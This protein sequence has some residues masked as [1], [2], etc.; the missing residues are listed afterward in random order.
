MTARRIGTPHRPSA[1]LCRRI[2]RH[3]RAFLAYD[4]LVPLGDPVDPR[5]SS[6]KLDAL[7]RWQDQ[8]Y[9][10]RLELLGH[11]V[12]SLADMREKAAYLLTYPRGDYLISGPGDLV[13]FLRSLVPQR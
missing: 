7:E 1:S 5:F 12:R 6:E 11:P 13:V 2:R 8:E 9:R 10:R 3:R 4:R